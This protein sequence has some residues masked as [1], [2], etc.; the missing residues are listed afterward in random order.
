MNSLQRL[1]KIGIYYPTGHAILDKATDRFMGQLVALAGDNPSVTLEDCG[2]SLMLENVELDRGL[3]FVQEFKMMLSALG[4]IAIIIDREITRQELHVFVRKMLSYKSK[5]LS[6]KQFTRIEVS[7]MPH[8]ITIKLKE[9]LARENASISDENAGESAENLESFIESLSDYGLSGEDISKCHTLLAS[10]PQRLTDSDID[11]RDLPHASW[12]DIARL[13]AR[14]MKADDQS[15]SD[16]GTRVKTHANINALASILKKLERET[17]DKKSRETINLLVSIIKRPLSDAEKDPD[18]AEK[19]VARVFPEKPELS[20]EQ[21]Q[22]HTTKNK[23]HPKILANI[24]ESSSNNETLSI[25]MQL[26]LHE[27][28]LQNQI[29][30]QQFFREILS[31]PILEKTWEILSRGLQAVVNGGKTTLISSVIRLVVEPLRR[32]QHANTLH[33]F[34]LTI[35][36]CDKKEAVILWPYV[37]NEILVNG[38]SPDPSSYHNLC[39][40]CA[41]FAPEDMYEALPQLQNLDSFQNTTIAP[42]IFHTLT[43]SCYPLFAFLLK[44]E[45]EQYIGERVIGGLRRNPTDWLI[46]AL[47]PLFDLSLEEHKLFL[48]S[49]LRQAS[50]KI[51]PAAIKSAAAKIVA[52]SLSALP[53]DRRNEPWVP[54]TIAAL[55]QLQTTEIHTL[56]EQIARE[57]KLLFIPEWPA[58]CRKAAENVLAASK[59][60][61]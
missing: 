32:S 40:F 57:K 1:F 7:E 9:F 24:P 5:V 28:T 61:R 53:Q 58:G 20:I 29:H 23:L 17:P 41:R 56:L 8:S 35:Q 4:I 19:T 15:D 34:F 36:L 16:I 47:V 37:V 45:I 48:Y 46:K 2:Q 13:L 22:E 30:M 10:L 38:S 39:R 55:V 3:P 51:I 59:R 21:L 33:L 60:R 12:D 50:R 44:T 49:Y 42:D 25:M 54:D 26:A 6:A 27:Q 31:A 14:A 52:A 11:M 18:E 43:P